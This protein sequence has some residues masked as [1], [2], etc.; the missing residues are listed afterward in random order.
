MV[1]IVRQIEALEAGRAAP[2]ARPWSVGG[3]V[4]VETLVNWSY[5]VQQVD[6]SGRS[7]LHQIEAAASGFEPSGYSG[8][9]CGAL[10]RME[11]LGC[12]VDTGRVSVRRDVHPAAE[13]VADLVEAMAAGRTIAYHGLHG[14]RPWGWAE[15]ERWFRAAVW[16]EEGAKAQV[17][18][19]ERGRSLDYCR[20]VAVTTPEQIERR[21]AEYV[22]W[23]DALDML[24]FHLGMKALGFAVT[25]PAAPR[26]PWVSV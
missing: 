25:S 5:Q 2:A 18:R 12:R 4:D 16:V 26:E 23:W 13:T 15:P 6:R 19:T 20:I 17:E 1:T 7:G 11:H 10:M 24:A 9:G 3:S 14:S 21:R 22:G 8:D